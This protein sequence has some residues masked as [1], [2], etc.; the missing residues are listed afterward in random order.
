M[1]S[2][3]TLPLISDRS[4]APGEGWY[5]LVPKGEFPHRESGVIQVVDAEALT[6]MLNRFNAE[7]SAPGFRGLLVDQEHFS[8]DTN[9]SSEAYG[10]VREVANRANGLWG[11]IEWT[12][13]GQAAVEGRQYKSL[14]PVWFPRDLETL[15]EKRARP[16]R[17]DAVGLTNMPNLQGMI[18]LSNRAP[19]DAAAE[20]KVPAEQGA[21]AEIG[22][23]LGLSGEAGVTEFLAA[24]SDLKAKLADFE[25]KFKAL[26]ESSADEAVSSLKNRYTPEVVASVRAQV[27]ADREAG[28]HIVKALAQRVSV[29]PPLHNRAMA[30][31]PGQHP[32][33]QPWENSSFE[34]R[35]KEA[36]TAV[37]ALMNRKGMP[38]K[39]AL[40]AVRA[41][42]PH[43]FRREED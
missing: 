41:E 1:K 14:S 6:A 7:A 21:L 12:P 18:P 17:L 20:T 9:K 37:N 28:M 22:T 5:H 35:F 34:A 39:E 23:A 42:R 43:L 4:K 33:G 3:L 15:G 24:V 19:D 31:N 27:I 26:T 13:L 11:R 25:S 8:Y 29:P 30:G 40:R 10:W 38:Y 2:K 36:K 16:T 32:G